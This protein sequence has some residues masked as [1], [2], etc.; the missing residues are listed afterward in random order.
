[1]DPIR[2]ILL[3]AGQTLNIPKEYEKKPVIARTADGMDF[4]ILEFEVT[5]DCD[6]IDVTSTHSPQQQFVKGHVST[7]VRLRARFEDFAALQ[8]VAALTRAHFCDRV[9]DINH[10]LTPDTRIQGRIHIVSCSMLYDPAMRFTDV[11]IEG[12]MDDHWRIEQPPM[13]KVD[14][15]HGVRSIDLS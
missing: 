2:S 13:V 7:N 6:Y 8:R 5:Q 4:E 12:F 11:D 3:D 15:S 1:M 10:Q 14:A 9:L